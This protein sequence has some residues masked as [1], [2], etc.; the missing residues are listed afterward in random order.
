MTPVNASRKMV[1]H[2]G[3]APSTPVWKT[4]V[5]LSTLMLGE[6]GAPCEMLLKRRKIFNS[7]GRG[8]WDP[9]RVIFCSLTKIVRKPNP[10]TFT[11]QQLAVCPCPRENLSRSIIRGSVVA[12]VRSHP[13]SGGRSARKQRRSH[14][15]R[16]A[17]VR[18][19]RSNR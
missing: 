6:I 18:A 16:C 7:S 5:F 14:W 8:E 9:K 19:P 2:E 15:A 3:I 4:V 12:F 10:Q 17:G 13:G 11:E 1:E